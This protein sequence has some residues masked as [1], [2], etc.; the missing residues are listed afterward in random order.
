MAQ[1][2]HRSRLKCA[3]SPTRPGHGTGW[4]EKNSPNTAPPAAFPRKSSPSTPQNANFGPFFVRR[5]NFVALTPTIRPSRANFFAH[6]ARQRGGIET[7]NT[8][9][10]PQQGTAETGITTAAE[11]RTKN[12]RFSP[13]KAMA[14][15]NPRKHARAKAT[16][17]SDNRAARSTGPGRSAAGGGGAWL[18]FETTHQ[19]THQQRK[20]RRCGGRRRD[21]RARAGFEID[22]SEPQA[23]VWRSRGRPGSPAPGTP[24]GHRATSN[25][26]TTCARKNGLRVKMCVRNRGFSRIDL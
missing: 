17:V 12:T 13:A 9:A 1:N 25:T 14:V 11:K 6:T 19:A 10:H 8:T 21:R 24:V 16:W 20:H 15:S 2:P 7:N 4:R 18:G 26:N 23:R 22:H 3:A 5:A